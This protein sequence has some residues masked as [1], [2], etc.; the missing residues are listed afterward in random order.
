[1]VLERI[2][3]PL[4]SGLWRDMDR[5]SP[6]APW[7]IRSAPGPKPSTPSPCG[8][9][10]QPGPTDDG[11]L[12]PATFDEPA[13]SRVTERRIASDI[14]PNPSDQVRE[15]ATVP[16][17]RKLAVDGDNIE[18]SSAHCTVAEGELI[19]H[20][21]LLDFEG[22][23]IDWETELKADLPPLLP[24]SEPFVTPVSTSNPERA[25][26]LCSPSAH[27]QH[28]ASSA[29]SL[30]SA[31]SLHGPGCTSSLCPTSSTGLLPPV[32]STLV[33]S[34]SSSAVDL[35]ISPL[36]RLPEPLAPPW[37]LGSL[38]SPWLVG[39]PSPPLAPPPP[40]PPRLVGPL[41]LAAIP[42]PWPLPQSAP[43]WATIMT[44]AWVQLG[45]S[46]SKPLL[47]PPWLLPPSLP[48][49]TLSAGPLLGVH[50]PP[51]L[52]PK[53][54]PA[55]PHVAYMIQG[56]PKRIKWMGARDQ[57]VLHTIMLLGGGAASLMCA[58]TLRQENYGGRI[59]MVS[60]D[61]L[62][63]YDKTRLSKV[64]HKICENWC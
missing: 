1:M 35:W 25:P 46:C 26:T 21:E 29:E 42:P 60:R 36:P 11:E 49:W 61:D 40:T 59:I 57:A 50:P 54:P 15:P 53:F 44:V 8:A 45:S 39:S 43:P 16:T 12:I 23:L 30:T 41:E 18:W 47:S 58:E 19:I 51:E 63:P 55:P 56:Q 37:P 5:H 34:R 7:M 2:S 32:S 48:P 3:P 4:W 64:R 62:L 22:D 17:T 20:L 38:A 10:H 14:E 9:E 52:P 31:S 24:S 27:H 6:S 33:L 13:Q 28:G